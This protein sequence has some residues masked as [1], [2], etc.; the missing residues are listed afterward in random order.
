MYKFD[1]VYA[2]STIKHVIFLCTLMPL[3]GLR[4]IFAL[5]FRNVYYFALAR[6]VRR[7]EAVDMKYQRQTDQPRDFHEH[8]KD[9]ERNNCRTLEKN[10]RARAQCDR[11]IVDVSFL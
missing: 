9:Q 10:F 11:K 8:W 5:I 7:N 3:F 6:F 4:S 1:E 2:R